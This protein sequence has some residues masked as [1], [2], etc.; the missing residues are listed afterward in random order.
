MDIPSV[1]AL[2]A[3]LLIGLSVHHMT[4]HRLPLIPRM[5]LLAFLGV[6]FWRTVALGI[7]TASLWGG[8]CA[9]LAVVCAWQ[10]IGSLYAGKT[11]L[12]WLVASGILTALVCW[13]S[14]GTGILLALAL[15]GFGLFQALLHEREESGAPFGR[16]SRQAVAQRWLRRWGR[17]WLLPLLAIHAL[18]LIAF[19]QTPFIMLDSPDPFPWTAFPIVSDGFPSGPVPGWF[20][21]ASG[22]PPA[23]GYF[24]TFHREFSA[25]FHPPPQGAPFLPELLARMAGGVTLPLI[26]ALP[27]IGILGAGSALPARFFYRTLRP[28]NEE[29]LLFLFASVA[30]ITATFSRSTAASIVA[31][32]AIPF[33]LGWM[34]LHDWLTAHPHAIRALWLAGT[35]WLLLLTASLL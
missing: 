21:K 22:L 10:D 4:R 19:R 13:A 29:R 11:G 3:G 8:G 20:G 1:S 28:E 27:V 14:P 25:L 18:G 2:V 32:G 33:T 7:A 34:V 16:L 17:G 15:G 30:L 9:L 35:I 24:T 5:A 12:R 26:G 6:A 31:D 23:F